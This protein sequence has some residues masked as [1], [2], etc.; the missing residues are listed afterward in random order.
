MS[1][2]EFILQLRRHIGTELLFLPGVTGIILQDMP[3]ANYKSDAILERSD[4]PQNNLLAN[5]LPQTTA[6][7]SGGCG[8]SGGACVVPPEP[9][10]GEIA[11]HVL[12]VKRA[13]NGNWTPVSGIMEP[14]EQPD[15][16]I[17]REILEET[18][19][20]A[21]VV[22]L[23]WSASVGP[24]TYRNGDQCGFLDTTFVCQLVDPTHYTPV[25][26]DDES[27]AVAW[28]PVS[29]LP[30]MKPRFQSLIRAAIGG[31]PAGFGDITEII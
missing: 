6:G 19:L 8:C 27:T 31:L 24:V 3:L 28:F 18:G 10:A 21:Q 12:L 4:Q 22:R 25:V 1:T 15:A 5:A 9:A 7:A 2:P 16:A 13:D 29:D 11:T 20:K 14:L 17:E 26:G 30:P 23:L